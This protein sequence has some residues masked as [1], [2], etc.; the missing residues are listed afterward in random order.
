MAILRVS[1]VML[2][3]AQVLRVAFASPKLRVKEVQVTGTRRLTPEDVVRFGQVKLGENI[4]RIN[5]ARVSDRLQA[6]P[7]IRHAVVTRDLPNALSVRV[8]ERQ[9]AFQVSCEGTRWDVDEESVL[10]RRAEGIVGGMPILEVPASA[11]PKPGGK[12]KP[13]WA[14]AVV[15]CAKLARRQKLDLRHM[16]VDNAGELWLSLAT[17]PPSSPQASSDET[18]EQSER[19]DEGETPEEAPAGRLKVRI[20]RATDLPQKFVDIRDSLKLW[21]GLSG[22]A[23]HL[24]VMC[25]GRPAYMQAAGHRS[26]TDS[27]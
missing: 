11:L 4:F 5:L 25:A 7:I 14:L 22:A 2:L 1:L 12:L 8:E 26:D 16:R 24:D 19:K 6:D 27:R 17:Q 10:F 15:E 13:E 9:P 3:C 23:A 18:A 21:P 20:G